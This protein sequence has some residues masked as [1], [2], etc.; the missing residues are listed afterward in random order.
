MPGYWSKRH[1]DAL[2]KAESAGS[3]GLRAIYLQLAA[4]YLSLQRS[5][6]ADLLK[7]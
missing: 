2:L 7:R 3:P 4:H 1:S 5:A 6:E